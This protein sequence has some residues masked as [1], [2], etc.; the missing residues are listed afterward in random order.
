[1]SGETTQILIKF[2]K[3]LIFKKFDTQQNYVLT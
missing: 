3:N 2:E 1:M